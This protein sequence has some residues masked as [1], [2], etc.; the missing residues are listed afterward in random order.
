MPLGLVSY[1]DD[2]DGSSTDEQTMSTIEH[3][4][5]QPSEELDPN[6]SLHSEMSQQ[7]DAR[8]RS[9]SPLPVE[10][11]ARM[12]MSLS[13]DRQLFVQER[14]KRLTDLLAPH[15]NEQDLGI[16]PE[17]TTLVDPD[18]LEKMEHFQKLRRSGQRLN[19]HLQNNKSFRNPNI[20]TKLMEFCQ[21]NETGSNF[22][23]EQY[24]PDGFPASSYLDG[25]LEVQARLAEEKAKQPRTRVEFVSSQPPAKNTSSM[26]T[27]TTVPLPTQ[28][29]TQARLAA[30]MA[31]AARI[32]AKIAHASLPELSPSSLTHKRSRSPPLDQQRQR[33]HSQHDKKKY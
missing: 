7:L 19:K 13:V 22:P 26:Q 31:N 14:S 23:L 25:I 27:R 20:Q 21:V 3:A 9:P 33:H 5:Q 1:S 24:N 10:Q 15:A 4:V 12:N 8:S 30:G 6:T 18:R 2:D 16:C 11:D 29:D 28:A 17:P 32:A